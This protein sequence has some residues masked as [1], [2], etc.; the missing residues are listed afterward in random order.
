VDFS[1]QEIVNILG[2]DSDEGA[3]ALQATLEQEG[4]DPSGVFRLGQRLVS[5]RWDNLL[6]LMDEHGPRRRGDTRPTVFLPALVEFNRWLGKDETGAVLE[7]QIKLMEMITLATG[8]R[9]LP[10]VAYNPWT[11]VATRRRH[12]KLIEGAVMRGGCIGV[13]IYPSAGFL[14]SGNT[15]DRFCR[16]PS[17]TADQINDVLR[18]FFSWCACNRVPVMVHTGYSRALCDKSLHNTAPKVWDDLLTANSGLPLHLGH[19]GGDNEFAQDGREW[20]KAYMSLMRQVKG[21]NLYVDIGFWDSLLS[22]D[23]NSYRFLQE[24]VLHDDVAVRRLMYG[25]DYQMLTFHCKWRQFP[26]AISN[27]IEQ[28]NLPDAAAVRSAV[29]FENAVRCFGLHRGG[30]GRKRLEGLFKS[31]GEGVRMSPWFERAD[32][33]AT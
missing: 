2:K 31:K 4:V 7:D 13:K 20:A 22:G 32:H 12:F 24:T 1:S 21:A 10:I 5:Y 6:E 18:E 33:V 16:P 14:P 17:V 29:F 19:F 9:V 11:D 3:N 27:A 8:G 30:K 28:A 26:D 15:A 25:S 23:K